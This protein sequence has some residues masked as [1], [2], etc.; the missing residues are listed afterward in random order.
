M[1]IA[2]LGATGQTGQYLVNQAL[3]QGHTVT[4]IVR[5]PGKLAVH[6]EKLKVVEADIFSADS[7]KVHFRG[8]DV[9]LSCLGFPISFFS[10][11]TGYSLS[12]SS[13]VAAMREARSGVNSPY[14]IRFLMLPMI[15]TLLTNMYEMEQFLQKTEDITWTVVRPAGLKNLPA[16]AQEFLTQEGYFVPN[17]KDYTVSHSVG[18]GDVA[19]F[20]L[21]LLNSNAWVKKGVAIATK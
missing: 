21:S 18:R 17:G 13:V 20:M 5:N 15:R 11:V 4:A 3:Q 10:A 16:S 19:R 14:L 7:L 12:M 9:I 8:Q 6:H 1:K 2:V